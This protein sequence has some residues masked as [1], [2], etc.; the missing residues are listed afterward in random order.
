MISIDDKTRS[1]AMLI[2]S[3]L[4]RAF[5]LGWG[6]LILSCI[7]GLFL[8]DQLYAV[9]SNMI[10]IPRPEYNAILFSWL[11]DMKLLLLIFFLM[12]A[13]AVRWALKKAS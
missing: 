3:V 13:I 5:F 1:A 10:A 8:T 4:F 9:H 6:L 7:P 11:G 12:P 2:S